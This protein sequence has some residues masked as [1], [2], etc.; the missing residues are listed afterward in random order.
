MDHLS[1]LLQA[2]YLLKQPFFGTLWWISN[3]IWQQS[4]LFKLKEEQKNGKHPGVSILQ[5]TAG[6][7]VFIPM[8]LGT[9]H[10]RKQTFIAKMNDAVKTRTYFGTLRPQPCPLACFADE[11][12]I[13]E[14]VAKNK[15]SQ[16][17]CKKLERFV[18][19]KL[20]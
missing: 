19:E 20:K 1:R 9:S 3:T 2:I 10:F 13:H 17:D 12:M 7:P 8:L 5:K 15:L 4:P 11:K 18:R 6:I 14:N 16:S